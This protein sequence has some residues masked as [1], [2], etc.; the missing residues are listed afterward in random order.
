MELIKYDAMINAISVCVSVDEVKDI[1]DKSVALEMYAKQAKN[2]DAE[3]KCATVRV[4]AER[5]CGILIKKMDKHK[6]GR[7]T[8]TPS[9][10]VGGIESPK[11]LKD[12]GIDYKESVQ[13]QKLADID[14]D[15]FEERIQAVLAEDAQ[16]PTASKIINNV[17]GTTGT[18]E[19]EWYTPPQ[20]IESAKNVMG[21]IHLDPASSELANK[22][23]DA[24]YFYTEEMDGLS[25]DWMGN[26]WMNPPYAQPHIEQ[27]MTKLADEYFIGNV[28]QAIA[29]THNYTDTKWFQYAQK[30]CTAI[31]FTRGRISFVNPEG[32][33][34]APTQGQA[35]FY[36]GEDVKAFFNEFS[37]YGF[38]VSPV[39]ML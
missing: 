35:F 10:L 9:E 6:G 5:Q 11:T 28:T 1:L 27:F 12:M 8:E 21:E 14:E 15:V 26:V 34:A 13:F 7:P 3:R 31:C 39:S 22:T 32:E 37:Q 4:R 16:K 24:E 18:G 2:F 33:K 17:R 20:F 29:L 19:N 25:Q 38:I 36:F 30:R 23:V